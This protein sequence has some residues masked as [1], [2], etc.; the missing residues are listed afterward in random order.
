MVSLQ[1]ARRERGA[2]LE[3]LSGDDLLN[4]VYNAIDEINR[5]ERELSAVLAT[6]DQAVLEFNRGFEEAGQ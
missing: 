5:L 2:Y 1:R 3:E 4:L 6:V